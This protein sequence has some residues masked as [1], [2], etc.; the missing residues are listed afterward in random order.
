MVLERY[1]V[2][3]ARLKGWGIQREQAEEAGLDVSRL[4]DDAAR[5]SETKEQRETREKA[6]R[7]I[8]SAGLS[9]DVLRR[10]GG[11]AAVVRMAATLEAMDDAQREKVVAQWRERQEQVEA[12]AL[13]L[14]SWMKD[15]MKRQLRDLTELRDQAPHLETIG[16]IELEEKVR[17]FMTTDAPP[18]AEAWSDPQP[19]NQRVQYQ[20]LQFAARLRPQD[21]RRFAAGMI[22][23]AQG[24]AGG[25]PEFRYVVGVTARDQVLLFP[26]LDRDYEAHT[27]ELSCRIPTPVNVNTARSAVMAAIL[28][29]L[30][31]RVGQRSAAG[32]R[33]GHRHPRARRARSPRGSSTSGR[34][35]TS[36]SGRSSSSSARRGRSPTRTSTRS[37]GTGSTRATPCSCARRCPSATPRATSTSSRRPGSSATRPA[38]RWPATGPARR[39]AWPR[40]AT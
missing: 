18:T 4:D 29:G 12:Q 10:F 26:Q 38:T 2:T 17:P 30:Q 20:P 32:R 3:L 9:L 31:S 8:R 27:L 21:T 28:T 39:C 11:D 22:A 14:D 1:G 6:E 36:S 13:K 35:A 15:E 34:R 7:T 16:R 40:R 19:I 23:R 5:K 37:T 33:P 24:I 25:A